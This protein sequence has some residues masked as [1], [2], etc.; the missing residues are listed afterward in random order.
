MAT[1][2]KQRLQIPWLASPPR[3][4]ATAPKQK[5]LLFSTKS[6]ILRFHPR[7]AGSYDLTQGTVHLSHPRDKGMSPSYCNP[8]VSLPAPF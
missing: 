4:L 3:A 5:E 2:P 7:P 8:R 6:A 1:G